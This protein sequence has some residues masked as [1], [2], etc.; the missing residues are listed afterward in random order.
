MKGVT[1][2][3]LLVPFFLTGCAITEQSVEDVSQQFQQGIQGQG[4]VISNNPASDSF[5]SENR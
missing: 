1:F 3:L 5:G 2:F 4:K